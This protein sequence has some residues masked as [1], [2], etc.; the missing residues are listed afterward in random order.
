MSKKTKKPI[1]PQT[2]E[3]E[4]VDY[5]EEFCNAG[6]GFDIVGEVAKRIG[7]TREQVE[8]MLEAHGF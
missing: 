1:E 2:D 8:E 6:S 7:T 3:A 4:P 5:F